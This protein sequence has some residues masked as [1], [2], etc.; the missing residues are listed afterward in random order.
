MDVDD[1]VQAQHLPEPAKLQQ[2][3]R[4][5]GQRQEV[6]I[7]S[8]LSNVG[9]IAG[10]LSDFTSRW[11][12]ITS[13]PRVLSWLRGY[14]IPFSSWPSQ[15]RPP[16]QLASSDSELQSSVRLVDEL[17]RMGAVRECS[18]KKDQFISRTFLVP[19]PDGSN[20]F[21]I[22]LKNLNNFIDPVHFKLEDGRTVCKLISQNC[23]MSSI[24]LKDAYYLLPVSKKNIGNPFFSIATKNSM[25]VHVYHS[26][27]V[28]HPLYTLNC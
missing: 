1:S 10:R 5:Q 12:K 24:D 25:N 19:K 3:S 26:V 28:L 7:P 14:E 21:I 22:N 9:K 23:F 2:E 20:R 13:D 4:K 15:E 8:P 16:L 17:L 6:S 18:P 27:Y 11:Q